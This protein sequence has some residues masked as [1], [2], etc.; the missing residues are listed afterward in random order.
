MWENICAHQDKTFTT[1]GRGR[2]PGTQFSYTV[3]SAEIFVSNRAKSITRSTVLYAYRKVREMEEQGIAVSGPKA[4][5]VHGDSYIFAVFK[6]IGVINAVGKH[7]NILDN[8]DRIE[9]QMT[10]K[11]ANP[12]PRPK[13][14]KN[15]KTTISTEVIETVESINEKIA[16]AEAAIATLTDDLK[17]KK[18]ELKQLVKQK[19]EAEAV[20]AKKKAEE[21]KAA[22]LAA[23]E[24]SGKSI[25]E[26]LE[27]LK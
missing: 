12:M 14:S 3:R 18:A 21:D 10:A 4:I 17:S 5:G 2:R 24:A 15:K 19:A 8:H 27:L 22:I 11:E 25:D 1:S 13:G 23:V 26:I 20:A 6:E 7:S 16:A 9:I